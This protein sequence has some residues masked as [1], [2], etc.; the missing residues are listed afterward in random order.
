MKRYL[1]LLF[2]I[3]LTGVL[4][5]QE[6]T[7][8]HELFVGYGF[9]PITSI[10]EPDLPIDVMVN[11]PY[12]TKNKRFS[13]TINIGY[14]FHVSDPLAIG[15]SYSYSTVKRDVVLGSSIP[16]AEI[17]NTCHT[18]MV[19]GKY[20]WLRLQRFSFYSRVGVGI[21]SVEKGK[22]DLFKVAPEYMDLSSVTMESDKCIAWQVMPIG[23]EWNFVKHLA[24]FTEI[25][26]GSAGCGIAGVKILF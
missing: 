5:A 23:I 18:V 17:K 13:G 20:S 10:P 4:Y 26:A 2:L 6:N 19:T 22:M 1:S 9:A 15:L 24:L 3:L 12:S 16:L 8:K 14:L 11:A 21:M 25:G 7:S